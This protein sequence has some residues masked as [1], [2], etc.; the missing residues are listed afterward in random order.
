MTVKLIDKHKIFTLKAKY[1]PSKR[2]A[3]CK[4]GFR[5]KNPMRFLVDPDHIYEEYKGRKRVLVCYVDNANR[6]SVELERVKTIVEDGVKKV[7]TVKENVEA[8]ETVRIHS[9]D[10]VDTEKAI[11]LDMLI[12]IAFW[13]NLA[14]KR[15]I[16]LSTV[17]TFLI[18]G[19]GI[20]TLIVTFLRACGI[21]V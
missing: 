11:K 20:Y 15:K 12:D 3:E 17:L 13:K 5:E 14:E 6:R 9:D 18:A 4:R 10:P 2:I 21:N 19:I 1:D 7:E 16:A 8:A